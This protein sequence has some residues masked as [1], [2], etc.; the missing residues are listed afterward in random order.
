MPLT[1]VKCG[2]CT[3]PSDE[4]LPEIKNLYEN[5]SE[6][7]ILLVPDHFSYLAEK[8]ICDTVGGVGLSNITVLTLHQMVRSL[9]DNNRL[10]SDVGKQML[11]KKS[12][13]SLDENNIFSR[14]RNKPG[15]IGEILGTVSMWKS[16]KLDERE[17]KKSAENIST[18]LL[19]EKLMTTADI[20]ADY[21]T[22]IEESGCIDDSDELKLAADEIRAN[23]KYKNAY[24]WVDEFGRF[25]PM[26]LDIISAF[27]E[28][29]ANIK[30][31]LPIDDDD[32]VKEDAPYTVSTYYELMKMCSERGFEFSSRT[33]TAKKKMS[34]D[35]LFL[36]Q[37]YSSSEVYGGRDRSISLM[38][39]DDIYSETEKVASE[40]IDLVKDD[41]Y[42][43]SD[44]AVMCGG[45]EGYT[46]CLEAIFEGYN[47]PYFSDYKVPLSGH[48]ISIL[49]LSVFEIVEG[50]KFPLRSMIRYLKTG[51]AAE[52]SDDADMICIYASSHN[53]VG[54]M[55]LNPKYFQFE[56][57]GFFDGVM[58]VEEREVANAEHLERVRRDIVLP[59][60]AYEER[61][62][63]KKTVSEHIEAFF[64]Y[65]T[66]INLFDR[67]EKRVK[68]CAASG[69]DNEASRLTHVWNIL[70]NIFDQMS[71][72]VGHDKITRE[73]FAEYLKAGIEGSSISIIPTVTNGVAVS[74]SSR[75]S[76]AAVKALFI[77]GAS[78]DAVP[79]VKSDDGF[80]T[81]N[82]LELLP[83]IPKTSSRREY[84]RRMET[85]FIRSVADT[86]DKLFISTCKEDFDGN[87]RTA[88]S[89]FDIISEKFPKCNIEYIS[90]A[91]I[92]KSVGAPKTMLHRLLTK[93]SGEE[94]LSAI[95]RCAVKWFEQNDKYKD[96]LG[97]IKEA[98]RYSALKG[99]IPK[100]ISAELYKKVTK[101]SVS[102]LEKY[103]KCPFSYFLSYGLSVS[104]ESDGTVQSTDTGS[105]IHYA[106][107]KFCK[108]IEG[109]AYTFD[110][111]RQ[112]WLYT[113]SI[114]CDRIIGEIIDDIRQSIDL[115]EK[116]KAIVKRIESTLNKT[117]ELIVTSII[118]SKYAILSCELDFSGFKLSNSEGSVELGG[119]I[120]RIDYFE[121]GDEKHMR[122]IDYK[123][124]NKPFS[125]EDILNGV[126]IQLIIYAMAAR[127]FGD[128][129]I[130][131]MFYNSLKKRVATGKTTEEAEI[132]LKGSYK[133]AGCVFE[134]FLENYDLTI[135][136]G[137]D[138]DY[139]L[140][141]SRK[142]SYLPLALRKNDDSYN[143]KLS[144]VDSKLMFSKMSG[145]VRD[146]VISA[147]NNITGGDVRVYP[148]KADSI[149]G[150][151]S[152]C[153]YGTICMF[154]ME[155][156]A[157]KNDGSRGKRIYSEL[158]EEENL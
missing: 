131:G 157:E 47:I 2:F 41:G 129:D 107:A 102:R 32:F 9:S 121:D 11:I 153:P 61:S 90:S 35:L 106:A 57:S 118:K 76:G 126:D 30:I 116:N 20:Y 24:I 8:R 44:I 139:E 4:Y 29:G 104:E 109:D 58:G 154:D 123:T 147:S 27:L 62:K 108:E 114:E 25:S 74:D 5:V 99:S 137:T 12:L 23:P 83:I 65:L 100:S 37:T 28:C 77:L 48:P 124:G 103:F 125:H 84:N 141:T 127:E 133:F 148:Y 39:A 66:E 10:L 145:Y 81:D 31:Y 21:K 134:D 60:C 13:M 15:F 85:E 45:L 14:S 63:G 101:Y 79:K 59:L 43:F 155:K 158:K 68:L 71:Y 34:E 138:M 80:F 22:L 113:D 140:P 115:D 111:K 72:S 16:H 88:S 122:I 149:G 135:K 119:I 36:C 6:E 33:A 67:I 18:E 117:A 75:R 53:I 98:D 110:E 95:D 86:T 70:I 56:R 130:T 54:S 42:K 146:M 49:I 150:A 73:E 46:S 136:S 142:S 96:A 144:S 17:L 51:Y 132:K 105:L 26:E 92:S 19:A 91:D 3:D 151:C 97:L 143:K 156:G 69:D 128:G 40:I 78:A 94:A 87:K 7:L 93:L 112:R 64:T 120:D 50:K 52:N 1:V 82:E 55:W 38:I 89:V 152:Y